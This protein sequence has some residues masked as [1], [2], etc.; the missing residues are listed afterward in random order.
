MKDKEDKIK[1][2]NFLRFLKSDNF[3][4]LKRIL[5]CGN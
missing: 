2:M 4:T 1:W 3:A 5:L